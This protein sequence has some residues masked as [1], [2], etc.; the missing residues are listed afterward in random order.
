VALTNPNTNPVVLNAT[1]L[2]SSGG[3]TIG[4]WLASGLYKIIVRNS[5]GVLIQTQDSVGDNTGTDVLPPNYL[6]GLDL[7][8][9]ALDP[10]NDID[11]AAGA[12]RDAAD[13]EDMT[14]ASALVKQTNAAWAVGTNAGGLDTG[15]LSAN[16]LYYV[17]LIKRTDTGVVDV[18]FSTSNSSPTMPTN[19]DK[20]R[21]IGSFKTGATAVIDPATL[22]G[23]TEA[24]PI[25]PS[26][27]RL[28]ELPD[29]LDVTRVTTAA[30]ALEWTSSTWFNGAYRMLELR[31]FNLAITNDNDGIDFFY[32][33]ASS[34]LATNY[35][36]AGGNVPN[37]SAISATSTTTGRI[38]LTGAT[39]MGNA[40]GEELSGVVRVFNPALA[41]VQKKTFYQSGYAN[42][43][44]VQI[45]EEGVYA[46]SSTAALD[47]IKLQVVTSASNT[48]AS[49]VVELWGYR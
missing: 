10:A 48:F 28:T 38:L 18:L 5:A 41:G 12:A 15:S 36:G 44:G 8:I 30:A 16:T 35:A 2:P 6:A 21:V 7:G 39:G 47:G 33:V 43:T 4:V 49:G 14:L 46:N 37:G 29:I 3:S 40:A 42:P 13:S 24:M 25:D 27:L 1:G 31:I 19:Y 11:I 22:F 17:W 45:W 9:N 34:Y 32:R 20:K 26:A 23:A